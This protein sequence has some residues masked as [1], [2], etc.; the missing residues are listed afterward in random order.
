MTDSQDPRLQSLG[1]AI[2]ALE[3]DIK[4]DKKEAEESRPRIVMDKKGLNLGIEFL[5]NIMV[6]ALVGYFMDDWLG[7]KPLFFLLFF[8]GGIAAGFYFLYRITLQNNKK[9][10]K[11]D[12]E[13][14]S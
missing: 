10:A 14:G 1:Q 7:T 8:F 9:V 6:P 13:Q 4:E 5:A 3:K 11:T 2:D 12:A